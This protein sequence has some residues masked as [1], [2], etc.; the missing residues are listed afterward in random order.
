[1]SLQRGHR[2]GPSVGIGGG[3]T[4]H[5]IARGGDQGAGDPIPRCPE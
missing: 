3:A 2:D 4:D 5:D 1:V